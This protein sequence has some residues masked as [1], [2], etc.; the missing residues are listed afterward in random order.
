[1][2]TAMH[3]SGRVLEVAVN[4]HIKAVPKLYSLETCR[5]FRLADTYSGALTNAIVGG[6]FILHMI[7]L[8]IL[9]LH[10]F[11]GNYAD[12]FFENR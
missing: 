5:V 2:R 9:E 4:N 7:F 12:S 3:D 1:M 8:S 11:Q 10:H 6:H